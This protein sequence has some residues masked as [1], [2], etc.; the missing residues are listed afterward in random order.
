MYY[1]ISEKKVRNFLSLKCFSGI[2]YKKIFDISTGYPTKFRV[3]SKCKTDS[4]ELQQSPTQNRTNL[5][6]YNLRSLK[7]SSGNG[8]LDMM[9]FFPYTLANKFI[10]AF[11]KVNHCI[12]VLSTWPIFFNFPLRL[13]QFKIR[14][15]HLVRTQTFPKN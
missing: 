1:R 11:N 12:D 3:S 9:I 4:K 2:P 5:S 6:V 13:H 10:F 15:Y 14:S 8:K 7:L